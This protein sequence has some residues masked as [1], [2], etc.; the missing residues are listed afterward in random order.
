MAQCNIDPDFSGCAQ[1]TAT[2]SQTTTTSFYNLTVDVDDQSC[3]EYI[4][5]VSGSTNIIVMNDFVHNDGFVNTGTVEVRGDVY[6]WCGWQLGNH[7]N[8]RPLR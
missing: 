3:T 6:L 1:Y 4:L 8:E 7:I 2:I 5:A